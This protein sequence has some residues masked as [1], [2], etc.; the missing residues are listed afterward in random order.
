MTIFFRF[1]V[2]FRCG[3]EPLHASRADF[4]TESW[5]SSPQGFA[6]LTRGRIPIHQL[7]SAVRWHYDLS[8][9]PP[10]MVPDLSICSQTLISQSRGEAFAHA[11]TA[12][13]K[14]RAH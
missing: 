6:A 11:V 1:D 3:S 5:L 7:L 2:A 13:G 14:R 10:K 12:E 8:L 9:L 4:L